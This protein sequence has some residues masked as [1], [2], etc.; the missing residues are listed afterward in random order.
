MRKDHLVR[1]LSIWIV[2]VNIVLL[3]LGRVQF[4]LKKT[5]QVLTARRTTCAE[6]GSFMGFWKYEILR[7]LTKAPPTIG[8]A[9][10][11]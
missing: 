6:L 7:F 10:R 4:R 8:D 2:Q 11:T 3:L 5:L 1:F 9:E